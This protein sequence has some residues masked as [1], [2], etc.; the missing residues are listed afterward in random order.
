MR[1][2]AGAHIQSRAERIAPFGYCP[3]LPMNS[4]TEP[5]F[6]RL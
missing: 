1:D 3:G 2:F 6:L 5:A 4:V